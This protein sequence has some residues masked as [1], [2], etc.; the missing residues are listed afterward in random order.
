MIC[1][2]TPSGLRAAV[3]ERVL[4]LVRPAGVVEEVC[5]G[6]REVDVTGLLDRLAAVERLGH[7]ELTRSL[8]EDSCDAEEVLGAL[9]RAQLR[10]AVDER[11]PGRGDGEIDVLGACLGHLG[12]HLLARRRDRREPLATAWLDLLATDEEPV[13]FLQA[14]DLPRLRRGRVLPLERSR[15]RRSCLLEIRHLSRS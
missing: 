1:A 6:E 14:D 11:L 4:E 2:A 9:G 5:G 3:G 13:A 10:P 15:G 12:Q 8:L 7:R